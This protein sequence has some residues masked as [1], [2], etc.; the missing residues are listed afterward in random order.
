M[1]QQYVEYFSGGGGPIFFCE[2]KIVEKRAPLKHTVIGE[3][4]GATCKVLHQKLLLGAPV[5]QGLKN[6]ALG[7]TQH[8]IPS[9]ELQLEHN[10]EPRAKYCIKNCY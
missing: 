7:T 10:K 3:Q 9:Q 4:Q 8:C 5:Q 1:W 6:C 2:R